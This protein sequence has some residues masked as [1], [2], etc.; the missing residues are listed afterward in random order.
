MITSLKVVMLY[1]QESGPSLK[2][3]ETQ[4]ICLP[5][6]VKLKDFDCLQLVYGRAGW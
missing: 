5:Q 1:L 4:K 6:V 3:E 2:F